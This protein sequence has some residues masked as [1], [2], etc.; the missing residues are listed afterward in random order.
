MSEISVNITK[1][2][3]N[4]LNAATQKILQQ[5]KLNN[6]DLQKSIDWQYSNDVFTLIANDYFEYVSTGRRPRAKKVPVEDII[7]WMKKKGI[8]PNAGQSYNQVAF[9]IT[10]A[11]YKNGIKAK[12]YINP[13]IDVTTELMSEDIATQL[14]EDI[15]TAIAND[16]S[17]TIGNQ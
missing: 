9:A 13:V 10:E 6:T 2:F 5:Y 7:K 16:L 8:S 15:A 4:E 11:I 17:F 1:E 12:N 14:S 3:L